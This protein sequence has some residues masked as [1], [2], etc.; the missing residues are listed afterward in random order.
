MPKKKEKTD[1]APVPHCGATI[2]CYGGKTRI[3]TGLPM[4]KEVNIIL[5]DGTNHHACFV[6]VCSGCGRVLKNKNETPI[7]FGRWI[8]KTDHGLFDIPREIWQGD[9]RYRKA[10]AWALVQ[11]LKELKELKF[12]FPA[13]DIA[14]LVDFDPV[15]NKNAET[16]DIWREATGV[17]P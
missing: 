8:R 7:C 15:P 13:A 17:Q 12:D 16:P 9:W 14:A 11:L 4:L 2:Q 1:K 3:C 5:A 6:A 10:F